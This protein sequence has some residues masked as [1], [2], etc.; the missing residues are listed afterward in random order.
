MSGWNFAD[1]WEVVADTF[2]DAPAQ[3]QGDRVVTWKQFDER[4]DGVGQWLLEIGAQQQDKVAQYMYNCPEYL[5]SMFGIFKTATVPVNTN[6][7]YGDEELLYL[8][9]NADAVAVIFH[10]TFAERIDA[11]RDK[12]PN[13]KGFLW[14]DD[15]TGT[16]PEWADPYEDAAALGKGR[17]T[18]SW[19]RS[20]DDLYMLYTGGTTGM[21]KGVMWRQDDIFA[22]LSWHPRRR[23]RRAHGTGRQGSA[24]GA[25]HARHR[26][27]H[28]L[29]VTEHRGLR[30]HADAA[31]VLT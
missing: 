4:A 3:I 24:G 9:D 18:P 31:H 10:G 22:S 11:L 29:H 15:G 19:G 26:L 13:I 21:P 23:A 8:W 16:C 6:Y 17:C 12:L 7:R 14:V 20:G 28:Q 25:A 30:R 27:L 5:E 2:P 1:V